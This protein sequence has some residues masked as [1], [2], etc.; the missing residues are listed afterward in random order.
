[1]TRSWGDGVN[2]AP[3]SRRGTPPDGVRLPAMM[4]DRYPLLM[5]AR[6]ATSF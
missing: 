6:R 4:S 3:C 1:M 2:S 5:P